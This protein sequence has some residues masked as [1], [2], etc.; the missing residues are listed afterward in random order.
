VNSKPRFRCDVRTMN[1]RR[2]ARL[3]RPYAMT[4]G[5]TRSVDGSTMPL[6]TLVVVNRFAT[7]GLSAL[8]FERADVVALC[9]E[10]QS[11][12]EVSALLDL[13]LGVTK[14][15]V[16]DLHAEGLLDVQPP[17]TGALGAPDAVLLGKVLDGLQA[18]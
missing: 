16:G 10:W 13:P 14:V 18:L 8:Q 4:G 9:N 11:V 15:L 2:E 7:A 6:E 17:T 12:A 5:R 3:V 1:D